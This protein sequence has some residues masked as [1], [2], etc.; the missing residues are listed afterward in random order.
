MK[1]DVLT[2]APPTGVRFERDTEVARLVKTLAQ[3]YYRLDTDID[4]LRRSRY[5]ESATGRE[6]DRIGRSVNVFRPDGES[7]SKFRRRVFAGF[8]RAQSTTT[9]EDFARVCLKV[10][11]ADPSDVRL[12]QDYSTDLGTIIVRVTTATLDASPFTNSEIVGLLEGAAPMSRRVVI[13][14]TDVFTWGDTDK[15]WGTQWGGDITGN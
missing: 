8:A 13:Q 5:I 1:D 2:A 4:T 3:L 7:D 9:F 12:A 10:L 14:P 15:G 11:D 6:L